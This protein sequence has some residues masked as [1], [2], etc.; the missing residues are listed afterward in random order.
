LHGHADR[1]SSV[2]FSRDG[3]T[4]A[5]A[6]GDGTVRLWD[7]RTRKALGAPLKGHT[8]PVSSVAFSP[9]GRTLASASADG[10]IRLWTG[11]LWRNV[12]ELQTEIC[13]LVG[14]GLSKSEWARY[15]P[16]I[17]YR[18]SCS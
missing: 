16:G 1:V 8:A 13:Q 6:S 2:A 4:L 9:D 11:L 12:A 5:S 3:R 15:A 10:T 14:S 7:V 18:N 17:P